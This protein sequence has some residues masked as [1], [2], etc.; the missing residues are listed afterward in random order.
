[1]VLSLGFKS[2][3]VL[4]V[5]L[6]RLCF[7][8]YMMAIYICIST[9]ASHNSYFKLGKQWVSTGVWLQQLICAILLMRSSIVVCLVLDSFPLKVRHSSHSILQLGLQYIVDV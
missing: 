2:T 3:H 5:I 8:Y 7:L 1:M 6:H 4:Y 9:G